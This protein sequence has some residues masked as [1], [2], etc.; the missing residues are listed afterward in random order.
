MDR[1]FPL[2]TVGLVAVLCAL[3]TIAGCR[4]GPSASAPPSSA[5]PTDSAR[6]E[7][8]PGQE[9]PASNSRV[10]NLERLEISTPGI[11]FVKP[12]HHLSSY[13]E[14]MID[15]IVVT[16]ARDTKGLS[17]T[18]VKRL[19]T[20][21]RE[22]TARELV[23]VDLDQLVTEPGPCVLRMQTAFVDVELPPGT[24]TSG[25][26]TRYVTSHGS[27][28]L[29]HELRDSLT[30]T[31]LLRYVGQRRAGGGAAVASDSRWIGLTR[32]F[33]MMLADLRTTLLEAVHYEK[34]TEGPL[35]QCQGRIHEKIGAR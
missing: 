25:A 11:L 29:V 16:F 28:I 22:A 32:T 34:A 6:Q 31:V 4:S 20:H 17:S 14:L 10:G 15:P 13:D 7:V 5:A 27:V 1:S 33:D 19:E 2:L 18:E 24:T 23:N 12:D 8:T 30:G 9:R 35:A 26:R 3:G 21:L